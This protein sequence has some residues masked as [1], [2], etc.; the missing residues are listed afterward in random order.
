MADR[1]LSQQLEAD[2]SHRH[3]ICIFSKQLCLMFEA[4][5]LAESFKEKNGGGG[6]GFVVKQDGMRP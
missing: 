1:Q 4:E 3:P 5:S 6:G 2:A